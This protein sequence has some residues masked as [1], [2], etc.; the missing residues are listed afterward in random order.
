[1]TLSGL[2]AI[3][4][5]MRALFVIILLAALVLPTVAV[6]ATQTL[7]ATHTYVMGDNDSRN[8]AR[9]LCFLVA[10]RKVL[11][12]AGSF[13]QS[14]SE[15]KNFDLTRDQI[16]SYSAAVLSVEIVKEDYGFTN[17]HNTLT[18]TVKADVDVADVQKRLKAIL[19]DK[20]LQGK[21]EGQQQEIRQL[22]QQVQA[23]NSRLSVAPITST[24]E[25]RKERTVVFGNIEELYKKKLA[26]VEAITGKTKLIR[27]FIVRNMTRAE[28]W[29]ILGQ[30]RSSFNAFKVGDRHEN[31]GDL[32]ICFEHDLVVGIGTSIHIPYTQDLS[33]SCVPN[34][35][36]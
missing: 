21:I 19:A 20:S 23:L 11:E 9:Q 4:H 35:L 2:R 7:T 30:S 34:E 32:W 36:K 27:Q 33:G 5:H 6:A 10:K 24:G 8:D 13:I 15:V 17:G 28:V 18:L 12:Q 25:L 3:L 31:Y 26:A 1:M 14:S 16:T 22:E 29:G